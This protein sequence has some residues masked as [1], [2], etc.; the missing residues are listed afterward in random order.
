[1]RARTDGDSAIMET[2]KA[3]TLLARRRLLQWLGAIGFGAPVPGLA[4]DAEDAAPQAGDLLVFAFGDRAGEP[5][6]PGDLPVAAPQAFA[7]AMDPASGVVRSGSRLNQVVVIRLD[8]AILSDETR[9]RSVEG[10]VAYSGVCSHTGCDVTDWDD[11]TGRFQCPCHE[12]QF[13]PADAARVVG[14]P[15]PWQ[16]A[17]LP[18]ALADGRLAVAGSFVGRVGFM[19]PGQDLFGL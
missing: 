13:D 16:L 19:Q 9:A 2:A 11:E 15:A 10:V 18:L 4:A 1:M 8:P 17:A 14:G 7:Y 6:A 5:I 12:S 3:I